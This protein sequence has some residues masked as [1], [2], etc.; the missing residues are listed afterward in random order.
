MWPRYLKTSNWK[1]NHYFGRI[2]TFRFFMVYF[3][4]FYVLG[5]GEP[6]LG[7]GFTFI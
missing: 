2:L 4:V 6:T 3:P 7:H 1:S 5:A